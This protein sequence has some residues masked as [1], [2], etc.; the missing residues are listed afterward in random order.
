M[1]QATIIGIDLAKRSFQVRDVHGVR[2]APGR[3][4]PGCG[5]VPP[6][7][8]RSLRRRENLDQPSDCV[9]YGRSVP[10]ERIAHP[11]SVVGYSQAGRFDC[12]LSASRDQARWPATQVVGSV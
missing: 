11:A 5:S 6:N 1:E 10:R 2:Q 3:T 4:P 12:A 9:Y 8:P 7:R